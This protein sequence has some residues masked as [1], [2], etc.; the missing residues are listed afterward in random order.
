M[1]EAWVA[2]TSS[3]DSKAC[4]RGHW[5]SC[6]D[7]KLRQL[8]EKYGPQNWNLIAEKLEG[9][10]GK[11]CRLRWFNQLNPEINKN[12]FTAAEEEKLLSAH[13]VHG[14]RWALIA[15]L[16]PGRT[17][18]AVKNHWHVI[19]ARWQ[20]EQSRAL[21][22]RNC[23]RHRLLGCSSR[24][25]NL[26]RF[27]R[28]TNS[29]ENSSRCLQFSASRFSGLQSPAS[30]H[31]AFS[32]S[33]SNS[34][35]SCGLSPATP[36]TASPSDCS[37]KPGCGVLGSSRCT[38]HRPLRRYCCTS[39]KCGSLGS[40][41]DRSNSFVLESSSSALLEGRENDE[42]EQRDESLKREDVTLIDFL[43]LGITS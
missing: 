28:P 16:F 20:R 5:R 12:P 30:W 1:E 25:G 26:D 2:T 21:A 38:A 8:V 31:G 14:N 29:E 10:S 23:D 34:S 13:R 19:N 37:S 39:P 33:S 18:N 17:D 41:S 9:R 22:K 6:E 15:R 24:R 43:G 35:P 27:A 7:E 4:S 40:Q 32:V 42:K 36:S 11:S 3:D